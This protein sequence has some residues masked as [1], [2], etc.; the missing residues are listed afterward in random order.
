M[1]QSIIRFFN[2]P[3]LVTIVA[4]II[5][6]PVG[7]IGYFAINRA[8]S[9]TF[10]QVQPGTIDQKD[11]ASAVRDLTL[12]FVSGGRIASVKVKAGDTVTS[13]Q[14]LAMLD[15]GNAAGILSQA[16]AAY[17]SA[18]ANYQ[19]VINGATGTAI[20]VAKAALNTAQ[21][22]LAEVTKQQNVLVEN[23]RR[24][25]L[26]S[27]LVA[28]SSSD[29]TLAAP[30]ISG[31][32]TKT[33]EGIITIETHPISGEGYFTASGLVTGTGDIKTTVPVAIGDSGLFIQFPSSSFSTSATWTISIP[34]TAS[35]TYLTNY[36]AYQ[37]AVQAKS[38]A[39]ASAQAVVDQAQAS[40][41]QTVSTARPE[42]VAAAEAQVES[43]R[44]SLQVAEAAYG[45]TVITA[46]GSGTVTAVF[47]APGQIAGA[48]SPA[49]EI[50]ATV[51]KKDVALMIPKSAVFVRNGS[52]Y[53][54]KKVGTSTVETSITTGLTDGT[55]VE[56]L[57]GL[58]NAD[59][60]ATH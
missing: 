1:K 5:A 43:A 29:T 26:N 20:D 34:N 42:D 24:T 10:V 54:L 9:Y 58:T 33:A 46:P 60:V 28:R 12:G 39:V 2:N 51:T 45:N 49:I 3:K 37:Q 25:Y 4:I 16:R 47:I 6:I 14:V 36:N 56:V 7:L 22:N 15:A 59:S 35:A 8:P 21:V 53:V 32:Y 31:A 27:G 57:T 44:G 40:L 13:G 50:L 41:T 11:A 23:A 19:K 17:A 30:T 18:Q 52:S 55:N 48:N 38:Q